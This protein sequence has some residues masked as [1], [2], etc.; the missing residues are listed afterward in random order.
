MKDTNE[1]LSKSKVREVVSIEPMLLQEEFVRM[2]SDLARYNHLYAQA[3][4]VHLLAKREVDRAWARAYLEEREQ[5]EKQSEATLKAKVEISDE[6][7]QARYHAV[8]AEVKLKEIGGVCEALR[9]K[10]DALISIGAH[11]R[12]ELGGSPRVREQYK[13]ARDVEST[14]A[15]DDVD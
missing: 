4:R 1:E 9:T 2:P 12:A 5:G 8:L 3:L 13:G 7:Q 6:Y 14:R 11:I 10:K 15:E